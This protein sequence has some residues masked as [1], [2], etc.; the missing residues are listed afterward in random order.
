[1]LEV[2]SPSVEDVI[3]AACKMRADLTKLS[4]YDRVGFDRV[5]NVVA[6]YR[7]SLSK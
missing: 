3:Q 2:I 5:L 7:R 6:K 1:V 4:G